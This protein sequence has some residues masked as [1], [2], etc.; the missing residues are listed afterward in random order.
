MEQVLLDL[1]AGPRKEGRRGHELRILSAWE[2]MQ[3][4]QEAETM[5]GPPETAAL[6]RNACILSRAAVRGGIG[7]FSSG[8]Q[9]LEQWSGEKISQEM[10]AYRR[11][12]T[13]VDPDCGQEDRVAEVMEALGREPMERIRWYVLKTFGVLPTESRARSMT[14]GDY[15]YCAAQLILDGVAE[16]EQLCPACRARMEQRR[17]R[18]C[19]APMEGELGQNPGFDMGRFEEMKR[20]G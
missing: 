16:Q 12:A 15:L 14:E 9:V 18:S 4:R 20:R 11:L 17:C 3:A 1:L 10:E 19:G 2:L 6:R 7:V 8:Q 13:K 5:G